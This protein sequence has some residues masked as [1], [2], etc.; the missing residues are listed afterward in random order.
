MA[1]KDDTLITA[2]GSDEAAPVADAVAAGAMEGSR[3][4]NR[5]VSHMGAVTFASIEARREATDGRSLTGIISPRLPA[6]LIRMARVTTGDD[7]DD[8]E[9]EEEEPDRSSA[10][11]A[12]NVGSKASR[13]DMSRD[14]ITTTIE[15]LICGSG[16]EIARVRAAREWNQRG[17]LSDTFEYSSSYHP[18]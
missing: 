14:R 1:A 17:S 3:R 13:S 4:K 6:L 2:D 7:D 10:R 15:G 18:W 16:K 8:E 9:E 12:S 5:D 11:A